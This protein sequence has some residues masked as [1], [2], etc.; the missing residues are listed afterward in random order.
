MDENALRDDDLTDML[1]ELRVLLMGAQL[2]TAF[3]MTL[4]FSPGF[5]RIVQSEKWIFLATFFCSVISL[6][7]FTAPAVQHRAVRPL[8]DRSGF[9]QLASRQMLMGSAALSCALVLGVELVAAEVF[10]HLLGVALSIITAVLIG[11]F[12][13][14]WPRLMKQ[15]FSLQGKFGSGEMPK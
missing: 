12:W 14:I 4:P 5:K 15:R 9:K 13:W 3:L 2:L 11:I 6:I 10:G 7:L 1:S 8:L